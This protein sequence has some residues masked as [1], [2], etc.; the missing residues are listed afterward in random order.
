MHP[1]DDLLDPVP[2]DVFYAWAVGVIGAVAV[3]PFT[4]RFVSIR[5]PRRGQAVLIG[6]HRKC[7]AKAQAR[8]STGIT[9]IA[10]ASLLH[11]H[12]LLVRGA[13]SFAVLPNWG[14]YCLCSV[15]V[16][17]SSTSLSVSG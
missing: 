14:K 13:R 1:N 3:S 7:T 2:R 8:C 16:T 17:E 10:V 15:W 5:G 9:W 11:F 12:Y 4:V 6:D